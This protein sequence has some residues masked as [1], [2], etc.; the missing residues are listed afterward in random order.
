MHALTACIGFFTNANIA[1]F[2]TQMSTFAANHLTPARATIVKEMVFFCNAKFGKKIL[3]SKGAR[4]SDHDMFLREIVRHCY[5][6]FPTDF[7]AL[8]PPPPDVIDLMRPFDA[9]VF[10]QHV[11]RRQKDTEEGLRYFGT[12]AS[13]TVA[14]V[15][16]DAEHDLECMEA[17]LRRKFVREADIAQM[18]RYMRGEGAPPAMAHPGA[19]RAGSKRAR[20]GD[21]GCAGTGSPAPPPQPRSGYVVQRVVQCWLPCSQGALGA[22]CGS[23]LVEPASDRPRIPSAGP[24]FTQA[25]SRECAPHTPTIAAK[26]VRAS[27]MPPARPQRLRRPACASVASTPSAPPTAACTAA[28]AA[29]PRRRAS[30]P[31]GA[32]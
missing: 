10:D 26:S 9:F 32:S 11:D 22:W 16:D 6:P 14:P 29:A 1:D 20:G 17:Y 19:P 27:R 18:L 8:A 30:A 23:S 5:A 3:D 31:A 12:V 13:V 28:C 25:H 21:E 4:S 15:F 24:R 7:P 2:Y